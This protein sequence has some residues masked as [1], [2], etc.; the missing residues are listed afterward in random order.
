ML[1]FVK[2]RVEPKDLSLEELWEI[3]EKEA[4]AALQAMQTQKVRS[5]YKVSGQRRVLGIFD[6][7]DHDELDRLLM[8][9]LP[10]AH[11][12]EAE[13]ILPLRDYEAFAED[14]MRRWG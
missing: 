7:A 3:W 10:L 11:H 2:L 6:V 14:V 1:F 9:A 5:L 13:E 8:A 12:L 4:G